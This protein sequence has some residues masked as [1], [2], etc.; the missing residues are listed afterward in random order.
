MKL[1][2]RSI[3]GVPNYEVY[4]CSFLTVLTVILGANLFLYP[5]SL[6]APVASVIVRE[7]QTSIDFFCTPSDNRVQLQW[8]FIQLG[9]STPVT[10]LT[11]SRTGV[12]IS[13]PLP[14]PVRTVQFDSSGQTAYL[15]NAQPNEAGVY[16]CSVAGDTGMLVT[17]VN[18]SVT[19]IRSE[20]SC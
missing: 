11:P 15:R 1:S 5:V 7:G 4:W 10:L 16:R 17:P 3:R 14:F 19:V 2:C 13:P 8:E 12:G 6:T 20:F 18:V 9:S